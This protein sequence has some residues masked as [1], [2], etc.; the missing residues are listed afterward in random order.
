MFIINYFVKKKNV[1]I[2]INFYLKFS[3]SS[4]NN[5][6]IIKNKLLNNNIVLLVYNKFFFKN[7]I[8]HKLIVNIILEYL[9]EIGLIKY[10]K[11]KK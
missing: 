5:N 4:N 10:Y 11:N 3:D 1:Q 2:F 6:Q 9:Y 8:N 7:L